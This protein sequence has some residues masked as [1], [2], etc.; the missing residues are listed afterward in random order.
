MIWETQG[1]NDL[2]KEYLWKEW[3]YNVHKRYWKYFEEWYDNLLDSQ[4]YFFKS[5]MEGHMS[6][7]H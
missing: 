1:Q 7:Y 5:W 3:Q 6:P 4:K 2:L